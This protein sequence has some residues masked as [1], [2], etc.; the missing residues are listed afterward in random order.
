MRF[1]LILSLLLVGCS[2]TEKRNSLLF[3]DGFNRG[4]RAMEMYN[5][6]ADEMRYIHKREQ[7][8]RRKK[9]ILKW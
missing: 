1:T 8:E 7:L 4:V 6:Q 5:P 3:I 2:T 9:H